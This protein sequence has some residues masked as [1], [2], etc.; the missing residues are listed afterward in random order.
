MKRPLK[1][2]VLGEGRQL[3][4]MALIHPDPVALLAGW[5]ADLQRQD[6]VTYDLYRRK[7]PDLERIPIIGRGSDDTFSI[8]RALDAQPDIAILSGG[9]GRPHARAR[10]CN[11]LK[12]PASRSCSSISLRIR[13]TTPFPACGC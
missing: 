5:P 7:F 3:I 13:S 11:G 4:A 1:R 2:I 10:W 9:Y 6:K 8:E 12:P